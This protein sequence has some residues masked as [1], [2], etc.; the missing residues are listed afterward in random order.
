VTKLLWVLVL[1][2]T[3]SALASVGRIS[4]L[5]GSASRKDKAGKREALRVG[6]A[7]EVG[8]SLEVE[9]GFLKVELTDG[10]VLALADKAKLMLNEAEFEGYER[11]GFKAFLSV[12]S[13]WTRVKKAVGG[14]KY[15]VQTDRAVAGVR[16]T[17]FRIDA[18]ALVKANKGRG[19]ARRASV[20]RVVEG[21]V[22]VRPSGQVASASK[23]Q[24]KKPAPKGPRTEVAG[25]SAVSEEKWEEIF[26]DLQKNEQLV[27][28]VD[29]WETAELD[30]ASRNDAFSKW[31][32]KH[33]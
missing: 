19:Q 1:C 11:K 12:G 9:E 25:P 4:V 2:V 10:S 7:V 17:I 8:D 29:L 15:E 32:E 21:I 5:E 18:D 33:P 26:V 31:L 23:G 13:L 20:V 14:A 22:N 28:G 6:S 24:V 16:G 30:A 27:V 3:P